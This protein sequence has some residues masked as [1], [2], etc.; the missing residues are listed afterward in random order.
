MRA[1]AKSIEVS[2]FV[3]ALICSQVDLA[4]GLIHG[5]RE[6]RRLSKRG[7]L[8]R[9]TYSAYHGCIPNEPVAAMLV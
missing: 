1:A 8:L 6:V 7:D 5:K 3:A 9:T 2:G 4:S